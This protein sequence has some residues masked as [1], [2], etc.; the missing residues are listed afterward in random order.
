MNAQKWQ[1][2]SS[3]KS[4]YQS[5]EVRKTLKSIYNDKCAYCEQRIIFPKKNQNK[6]AG[7][8]LT[9]EHFRP[10]TVYYWLAYSWDNLLP[11]CYDCNRHK[12]DDFDVLGTKITAIR[13]GE[14]DEIHELAESYHSEEKPTFIHPELEDLSAEFTFD[15]EGIIYTQNE[16]CQYVIEKCDL[17]R[18]IL[19]QK[20]KA[21][22]D[23]IKADFKAI[24]NQAEFEKLIISIK[25]DSEKQRKEFRVLYRYILRDFQMIIT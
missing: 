9:I 10:K 17:K 24:K 14:I 7:N 23:K 18:E 3:Y 15:K 22:I 4:P 20:R 16:R 11:V 25:N 5:K 19:N 8:D 21:I 12:E 2:S 1:N 6:S 13:T